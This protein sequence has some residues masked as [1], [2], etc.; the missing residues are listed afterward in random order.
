MPLKVSGGF[1]SPFMAE[2]AEQFN[3]YLQNVYF[4]TF[5]VPL[6]S[7]YTAKPYDRSCQELLVK[8]ICNP[9]RW[10]DLVENMIGRRGGHFY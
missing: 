7:N 5:K 2:A 8:Q 6:Y 3:A 10:Q 4:S 1:H 9:V